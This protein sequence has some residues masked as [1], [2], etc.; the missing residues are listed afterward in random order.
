[1][2]SEKQKSKKTE[3]PLWR[4]SLL[5]FVDLTGWITGPIILAVIFGMWLDRKMGTGSKWMIVGV[6]MAF[7]FSMYKIISL[8]IQEAKKNEAEDKLNKNKK[9]KK[10]IY[11]DRSDD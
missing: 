4:N 2:K 5:F 10:R 7:A 1:M 11:Y 3:L 6:I 8:A 9:V